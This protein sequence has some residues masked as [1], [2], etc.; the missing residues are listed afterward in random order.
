M[1][2]ARAPQRGASVSGCDGWHSEP[3]AAAKDD[4]RPDGDAA[5]ST[6]FRALVEAAYLVGNADDYFDENER[7]SFARVVEE[8]CDHAVTATELERLV[9]DLA[10]DLATAGMDER[11]TAV[12]DGVHTDEE[13][14]AVL[15]VAAVMAYAS[16]GLN[17]SE[18]GVLDRLGVA[19]GL[20][21]DEA[22]ALIDQVAAQCSD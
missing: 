7:G 11:I 17:A 18:R 9:G 16:A 8:E 14:H 3:A 6:L 1:Q 21:A 19:M 13:R 4:K 12:A 10:F 22:A 5:G 20:N 15:R 2:Q